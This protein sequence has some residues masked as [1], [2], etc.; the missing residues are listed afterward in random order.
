MACTG[1]CSSEHNRNRKNVLESNG[2]GRLPYNRGCPWVNKQNTGYTPTCTEQH[3]NEKKPPLYGLLWP[4]C[5]CKFDMAQ[6][7]K[8]GKPI[9]KSCFIVYTKI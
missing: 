3:R 4:K 2:E 6:G 1:G 8:L 9:D 7:K 5:N